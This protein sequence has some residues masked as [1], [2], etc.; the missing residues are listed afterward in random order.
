VLIDDDALC[1]SREATMMMK[2]YFFNFNNIFKSLSQEGR[3]DCEETQN[4]GMFR[5]VAL[6]FLHKTVK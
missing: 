1:L 3:R 2:C 4:H 5:G 6:L